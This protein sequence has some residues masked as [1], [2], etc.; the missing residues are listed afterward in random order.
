MFLRR[1]ANLYD[2][3]VS[4]V[5]TFRIEVVEGSF[6]Q[7]R[8]VTSMRPGESEKFS[9]MCSRRQT[10]LMDSLDSA[11]A[12]G[13]LAN[14]A[15]DPGALNATEA[16]SGLVKSSQESREADSVCPYKVCVWGGGR[17]GQLFAWILAGSPHLPATAQAD[18]VA[19]QR[20]QRHGV[21]VTICTAREDL[22]DASVKNGGV[23][24]AVQSLAGT[25]S[26]PDTAPS[27]ALAV[28][29]SCNPERAVK[30]GFMLTGAITGSP[31]DTTM[32]GEKRPVKVISRNAA[33]TLGPIFDLV[34]IAC[35][36]AQTQ[37]LGALRPSPP[38]LLMCCP[39][40]AWEVASLCCGLKCCGR[41]T[42]TA[43]ASRRRNRPNIRQRR[44]YPG[45]PAG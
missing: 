9:A 6:P 37:E 31:L 23:L 33:E 34:I 30:R 44:H 4:A 39:S 15:G 8:N 42:L 27:A 28:S 41:G 17:M 10:A 3:A 5:G 26:L 38:Y 19:W 43:A 18:S 14:S 22:I 24:E 13:S 21:E 12:K 1:Y 16:G 36:S 2:I 35:H 29:N 32:A 20:M 7:P 11:P 40:A 25:N 45:R